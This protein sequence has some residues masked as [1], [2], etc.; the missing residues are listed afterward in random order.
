VHADDRVRTLGRRGDLRD[1][2]GRRVR[3]ENRAGLD[4]TVQGLEQ[5]ELDVELLGPVIF[6]SSTPRCRFFAIVSTPFWTN[7]SVRSRMTTVR[8]ERAATCAMP[9]P[10]CPAPTT[11]GVAI[12]IVPPP[13]QK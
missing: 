10:I 12:V 11:P 3:R 2:K 8:P 4:E 5:L 13:T 7:A 1:R 6:P 9:F